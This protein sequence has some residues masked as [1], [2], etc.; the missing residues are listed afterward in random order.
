MT[1]F[2]NNAIVN[3]D[4][5]DSLRDVND[6]LVSGS[7]SGEQNRR[8]S[9][10][11]KSFRKIV[12]GEEV[13]VSEENNM[14]MVILNAAKL[15]RTYYEGTYTPGNVTP[16]VCWSA[17]TKEPSPD[18]PEDQRQAKRCLDCPQ[19]VK[20]SGQGESRA[21]RFAQRIAVALEGQLDEVYQLQIPATSIFG[22]AKDGNMPM[23]AYANFLNSHNVPAIAVV[24]N[25]RF[26]KGANVPKL[27]FKA[28]R[29]L[30]EAELEQVVPLKDDPATL[31]AIAL[32]VAQTDKVDHFTPKE[33]VAA[34]S[35]KPVKEPTKVVTKKAA[36]APDSDDD[37]SS[38]IDDW[39]D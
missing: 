6:N 34:K 22:T 25:M 7:G 19:N 11:G 27:F 10:A 37:L 5:F 1:L 3:S 14:N 20:G 29:P 24:T 2:E 33:E 26:D 4:L 13:Y 35:E 38:I 15:S 39:D 31:K 17:D 18:V 28:V 9:L 8:I 30:D 23:Q 32:T 36:P 16:P 21:C 12:N